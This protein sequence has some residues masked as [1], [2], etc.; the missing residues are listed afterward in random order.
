MTR[1]KTGS[2]FF[3]CNEIHL[4]L[5]NKQ[6]GDDWRVLFMKRYVGILIFFVSLILICVGIDKIRS[7]GCLPYHKET[8][9]YYDKIEKLEKAKNNFEKK[10]FQALEEK[11]KE[12]IRS[13][14]SKKALER[15][16]DLEEGCQYIFDL[17]G[18]YK[19]KTVKDYYSPYY[20]ALYDSQEYNSMILEAYCIFQTNGHDYQV[21]WK[22][23]VHDNDSSSIGVYGIEIKNVNEPS[24]L[25]LYLAGIDHPGRQT[26]YSY[27]S[28]LYSYKDYGTSNNKY[29]LPAEKTWN[30]MFDPDVLATVPDQDKYYMFCFFEIGHDNMFYSTWIKNTI[31]GQVV[32]MEASI[33]ETLTMLSIRTN[34]MGK[35]SGIKVDLKL[36]ITDVPDGIT[37]FNSD[38]FEKANVYKM[39]AVF[40][41]KASHEKTTT[42]A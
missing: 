42:K 2:R 40:I 7:S 36:K 14:F 3:L 6:T 28:R 23:I 21:Y 39:P 17:C 13:L 20:Y 41:E 34:S 29:C 10:L 26:A 30:D 32:Y 33:S 12:T 27:V 24:P 4:H 18:G 9:T 8:T 5:L 11:D 15:C 1:T 31:E 19:I 25:H 22:Q 16:N 35:I 38:L 37:G